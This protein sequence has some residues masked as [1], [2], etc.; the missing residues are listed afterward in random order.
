MFSE[1]MNS[2]FF[3]YNLLH[4]PSAKLDHKAPILYKSKG[5]LLER[6]SSLG[7]DHSFIPGFIS[8]PA[9]LVIIDHFNLKQNDTSGY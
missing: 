8:S 9:Q 6:Q 3:A 4:L 7:K 1:Q 5:R 2:L